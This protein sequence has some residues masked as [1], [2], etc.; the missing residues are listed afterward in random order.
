M[1]IGIFGV[2]DL[3]PDVDTGR[4]QTEQERITGVA[5][6]A[7]HAEDVGLDVYALG[8]HHNPPFIPARRR[9]SSPTSR[10]RRSG[11]SSPRPRR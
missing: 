9:R 8:E 4:T 5:R 1:E 10:R 11:S 3:H 6:I 7:K 2:G